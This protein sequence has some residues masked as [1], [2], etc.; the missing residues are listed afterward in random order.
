MISIFVNSLTNF[1]FLVSIRFN[2]IKNNY[3]NFKDLNFKEFDFNN[4]KKIK[5]YTLQSNFIYNISKIDIHNFDFLL[6]YQKIGGK[7]GINLS[8]KNIF[9]WFKKYK[10]YK[11]FPWKDDYASKRFINILYN[12]D[13]ICSLSNEKE[14]K[15]LKI[16]WVFL[17]ISLK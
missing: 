6:F 17:R 3:V 9:N 4:Y 5:H 10:N 7:K 12:Y 2:F 14:I 13:Y 15:Q 11:N 8:K 16:I 1:L